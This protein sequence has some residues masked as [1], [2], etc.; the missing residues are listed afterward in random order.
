MIPFP[1]ETLKVLE[2]LKKSRIPIPEK[3]SHSPLKLLGIVYRRDMEGYGGTLRDSG[4]L[5][6]DG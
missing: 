1:V 6:I 5:Y 4:G 2:R 3:L